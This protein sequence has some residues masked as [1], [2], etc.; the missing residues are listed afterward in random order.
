MDEIDLAIKSAQLAC[1]YGLVKAGVGVRDGVIVAIAEDSA[2]PPAKKVIEAERHIII[3]GA[4]DAHVH[5]RDPGHPEKEDFTT[6]TMA[7][8]A[9]GVTTVLEHPPS[10]PS[11]HSVETFSYKR[12]IAER[13]AVVDFGLYGGAGT[14]SINEIMPLAESGVVAFKTFLTTSPPDRIEEHRGLEVEG[15]GALLDV[16]SVVA[17]TGLVNCIHAENDEIIQHRM[18]QLIASGQVAATTVNI[19]RPVVAEV[20]AVSR[21]ILFA[22]DTGV[23]LHICHVS[24]GSAAEIISNAKDAGISVTAETCPHYLLQTDEC[25]QKLGPYGKVHPPIRSQEEQDK[26]WHYLLNGAIDIICT[27]HAPHS[28]D[29]KEQGR[30]NIF[31]APGGYPGLETMVPLLLT[32]VNR[33]RL[34]LNL[35]TKLISENVAKIFGLFPRKGAIHVGADADLVIVD[36]TKRQTIKADKLY[37]RSRG[38]ALLF[39]GWQTV[40]APIMTIVRGE[41]VMEDGV[42]IG[43]PGYGKFIS[44]LN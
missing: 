11:V 29:L 3:P 19:A 10:V 36:M 17:K 35:L 40:G 8:A 13:K 38:S 27:D 15:D 41:V 31:H 42:V 34:N 16:F 23:R 32:E 4:I 14:T 6:G 39:E 5:L 44:P 2:L 1:P 37:T 33:G 21:A 25:M 9:G 7:A 12:A 26:L 24:S 28:T 30:E 22:K 18:K 43:P 20:E